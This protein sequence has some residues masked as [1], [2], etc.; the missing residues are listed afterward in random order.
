MSVHPLSV[1]AVAS[2]ARAA[3]LQFDPLAA[4]A[5][6]ARRF[7]RAPS[8]VWGL[9]PEQVPEVLVIGR[10]V[11]G[12]GRHTLD[13]FV[14]IPTYP[15]NAPLSI[16]SWTRCMLTGRPRRNGTISGATRW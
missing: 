6:D 9:S 16:E 15:W 3:D 7:A 10:I 8:L 14:G 11:D 13:R 1:L 12:G 5:R 4:L 2:R